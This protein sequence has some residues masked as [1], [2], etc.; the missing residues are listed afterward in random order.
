MSAAAYEIAASQLCSAELS[1][2]PSTSE[3]AVEHAAYP[4]TYNRC[5]SSPDQPAAAYM[6]CIAQAD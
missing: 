5:G 6:Q 2:K 4:G 3:P 1:F